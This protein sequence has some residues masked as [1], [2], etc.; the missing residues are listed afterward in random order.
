MEAGE[1][2]TVDS[3]ADTGPGFTVT[4]TT[5]VISVPFA[6]ADTVFI[7]ATVELRVPLANPL[8]LV[9]PLGCVTVLPLPVAASS[10]VAPPIGLPP[11]SF[12]VT[13]IVELPL[14]AVSEVGDAP[15]VD[16]EAEAAGPE[17]GAPWQAVEPASVKVLPATG[18]NF[19]S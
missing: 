13:L 18:M 5:C 3:E 2:A 17:P 1:A 10:T 19:Q 15:S 6:M 4:V 11:A 16:C 12:T 7:S 9:V 8:A 14:P